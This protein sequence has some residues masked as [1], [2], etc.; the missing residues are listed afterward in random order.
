MRAMMCVAAVAAVI[1]S[2]CV[3]GGGARRSSSKCETVGKIKECSCG[4]GVT[5][6]KTCGDDNKWSDC[7]CPATGDDGT[8]VR[9]GIGV[10]GAEGD[11]VGTPDDGIAD[12]NGGTPGD[13]A[14]DDNGGTPGDG[15][16]DDNGGTPGDGAADENG[17]TP[18]DGADDAGDGG[19]G[20]DVGGVDDGGTGP[21]SCMEEPTCECMFE[22]CSPELPVPPSQACPMLESFGGC[23]DVMLWTYAEVGCGSSENPAWVKAACDEPE[24]APLLEQLGQIDGPNPCEQECIPDCAG[25]SCGDDLCGGTCGACGD[26]EQ[27]TGPGQC[28]LVD[29]DCE[30]TGCPSGYECTGIG[31]CQVMGGIVPA[32]CG[33]AHGLVGCCGPDNSVYWWENGALQGEPENCG[34]QVCGWDATNNWYAC[35]EASTAGGDPSGEFPLACGLPNP[36]PGGCTAE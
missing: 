5:A 30:V 12:G 35:N 14:A 24:C 18:G 22:E 33:E 13:G 32:T 16:A 9:D 27:C 17:G 19:P 26:G 21:V 3:A 25:K 23:L 11:G 28:E 8:P 36:D 29:T 2:G 31:K 1:S 15:A 6:T 7:S 10:D 20:D 34:D 4:G